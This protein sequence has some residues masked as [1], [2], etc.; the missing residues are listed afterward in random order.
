MFFGIKKKKHDFKKL[1]NER[2]KKNMETLFDIKLIKSRV[3]LGTSISRGS[4]RL[5]SAA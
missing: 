5:S 1:E 4:T 3:E 2:F